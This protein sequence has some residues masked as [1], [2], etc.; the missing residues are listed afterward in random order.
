MEI[1]SLI[2]KGAISIVTDS[3]RIEKSIFD[4]SDDTIIRSSSIIG[5]HLYANTNLLEISDSVFE[6]GYAKKGGAIY[7]SAF[8]NSHFLINRCRVLNNQASFSESQSRGGGFYIE[9]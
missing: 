6:G 4:N 5:G 1:S 7:F 2:G 9:N 3:L 8:G